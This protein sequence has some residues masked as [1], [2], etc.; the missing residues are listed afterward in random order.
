VG[1][2]KYIHSLVRKPEGKRP[3]GEHSRCWDDSFKMD[4]EKIVCEGLNCIHL[5][6]DSVHFQA[7]VNTVL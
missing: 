6:Q 5:A 3:L 7:G 1:D 4:K 2:E